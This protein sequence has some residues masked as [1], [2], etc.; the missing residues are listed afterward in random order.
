[1]SSRKVRAGAMSSRDMHCCNM[2]TTAASAVIAG[3]GIGGQSQTA[4]QEN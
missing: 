3:G 1:M 4:K 2:I